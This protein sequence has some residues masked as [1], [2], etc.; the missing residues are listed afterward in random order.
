[1]HFLIRTAVN[2]ILIKYSCLN[3]DNMLDRANDSVWPSLEWKYM[4]LDNLGP[5]PLGL[6]KSAQGLGFA[7]LCEALTTNDGFLGEI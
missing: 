1:M 3:L 7:M 6:R 5:D 2:I 4:K